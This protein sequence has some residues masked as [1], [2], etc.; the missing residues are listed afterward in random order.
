MHL[1]AYSIVAYRE[2]LDEWVE[3]LETI[4]SR[5][6]DACQWMMEYM[7]SEEGAAFIR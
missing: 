7:A 2:D 4:L 6:K 5:C 3:V 1:Y